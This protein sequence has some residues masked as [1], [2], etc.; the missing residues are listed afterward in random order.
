MELLLLRLHGES[1]QR[2][3]VFAANPP[4]RPTDVSKTRRPL[5][6][7][8]PQMS[9]SAEVGLSLRREPRKEPSAPMKSCVLYRVPPSRSVKPM[10]TTHEFCRAA[11]PTVDT[12]GSSRVQA[13]RN[14]SRWKAMLRFTP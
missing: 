1:R 14:N 7:P 13:F 10:I 11:A 12:H 6:S 4:S 5:P 8:S 9:R 3:V 2:E